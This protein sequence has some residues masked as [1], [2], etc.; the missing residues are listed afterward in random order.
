MLLGRLRIA[1][2]HNDDIFKLV[3]SN[4]DSM[5]DQLVLQ[6]WYAVQSKRGTA[7][8]SMARRDT[9]LRALRGEGGP[10]VMPD[11]FPYY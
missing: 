1:S 3:M 8:F 7:R 6:H 10:C 4:A 9:S 2:S 5:R 11:L